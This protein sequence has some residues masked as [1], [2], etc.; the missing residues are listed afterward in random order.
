VI[1]AAWDA[2]LVRA[3]EPRGIHHRQQ[4]VEIERLDEHRLGAVAPTMLA[5]M[6]IAVPDSMTEPAL[7]LEG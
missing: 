5:L 6:G 3:A 2:A 1:G 4:T 7:I